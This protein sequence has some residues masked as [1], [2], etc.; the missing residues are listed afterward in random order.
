MVL[1]IDL[2]NFVRKAEHNCMTRPHPL[3]NIYNIHDASCLLLYFLWDLFVR[4]WFFCA[5]KVTP[6]MLQKSDFLLQ[7]FRVIGQSVF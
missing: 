3:F 6:E 5:L 4:L 2:Y 1:E 7:F